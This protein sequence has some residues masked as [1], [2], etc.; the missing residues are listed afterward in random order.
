MF[1][2]C[3]TPP[4]Q[5]YIQVGRKN[6]SYLGEFESEFKKAL[7]CE[8]GAQGILFDEKKTDLISW[9]CPFN[10]MKM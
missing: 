9:H 4:L 6:L 10:I 8:W 2:N 3:P 7:A 1:S 5:K